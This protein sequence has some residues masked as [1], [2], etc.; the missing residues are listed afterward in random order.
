M[1]IRPRVGKR[2]IAL[3]F[4]GCTTLEVLDGLFS[5][6]FWGDSPEGL[7][8]FGLQFTKE[9]DRALTLRAER[10]ACL[11]KVLGVVCPVSGSNDGGVTRGTYKVP[12]R[13]DVIPSLQ[14]G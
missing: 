7:F 8:W 2:S 11:A 1:D 4:G 6:A 12:E 5:K 10:H 13:R 3:R 14:C 9:S